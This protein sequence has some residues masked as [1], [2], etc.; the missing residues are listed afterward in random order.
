M[1]KHSFILTPSSWLGEG[2]IKL[3]MVE[4]ELGFFTTM[5]CI[6]YDQTEKLN[7][8][9]RSKSKDSLT[10]CIMNLIFYNLSRAEFGIST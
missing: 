6:F 5:E 2:K 10:S 3:N 8:S 1:S 4:E 7:V 9:K